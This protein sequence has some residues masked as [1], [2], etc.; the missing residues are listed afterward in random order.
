MKSKN[1]TKQGVEDKTFLL[2]LARDY[3][4]TFYMSEFVSLEKRQSR[5]IDS[6]TVTL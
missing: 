4:A 5:T 2:L 3:T 6:N 1:G